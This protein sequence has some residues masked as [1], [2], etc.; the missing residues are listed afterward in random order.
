MRAAIASHASTQASGRRVAPQMSSAQGATPRALALPKLNLGALVAGMAAAQLTLA[1]VYAP[2]LAEQA[3]SVDLLAESPSDVISEIEDA[4]I[5]A[6]EARLGELASREGSSQ[7]AVKA[8]ESALEDIERE[9]SNVAQQ[10]AAGGRANE[11][12]ETAGILGQLTALKALF[13]GI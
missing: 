3:P 12:A 13:R 2:A 5:P 11:G 6:L 1:P 10:E 8:A 4:E 7:A 9:A